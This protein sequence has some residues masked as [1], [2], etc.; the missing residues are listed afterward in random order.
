MDLVAERAK[1]VVPTIKVADFG[2]NLTSTS[3]H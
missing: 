2:S 3:K 1:L